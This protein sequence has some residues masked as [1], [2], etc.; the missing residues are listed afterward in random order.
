MKKIKNKKNPN[1]T[2]KKKK[3]GEKNENMKK[4]RESQ[5]LKFAAS[6]HPKYNACR[7]LC[8]EIVYQKY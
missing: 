1:K 6:V 7:T 8:E 2:N 4:W 5:G 3:Q